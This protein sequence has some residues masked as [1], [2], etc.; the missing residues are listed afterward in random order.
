MSLETERKS[1]LELKKK[2][3]SD[4]LKASWIF[5]SFFDKFMVVFLGVMGMWK[6][7][8]LLSNIIK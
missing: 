2:H 3:F 7:F 4:N 1:I 5:E 6:I 8:G